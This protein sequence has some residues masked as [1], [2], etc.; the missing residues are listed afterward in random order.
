[1]EGRLAVGSRAF[2]T[3]DAG[4][5]GIAPA[6]NVGAARQAILRGLR[7][8]TE[9]KLGPVAPHDV[10]LTLRRGEELVGGFVGVVSMGWLFVE[11][12]WVDVEVRG[13]GHG[14]AL[15]DRGESEARR[16]GASNSFLNTFSF[17]APAFYARLGYRTYARLDDFPAGHQ[18][19]FM[20]KTL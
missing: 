6:R 11:A 18:R 2:E 12:L 1:M 10:V 15:M 3:R 9:A 13:A 20:T 5:P 14:R 19:I 7:A 4:A 16:Q 8:S 17:Q